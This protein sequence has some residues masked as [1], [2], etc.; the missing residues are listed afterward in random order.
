MAEDATNSIAAGRYRFRDAMSNLAR[1][2]SLLEADEADDPAAAALERI[3]LDLAE[4]E[5]MPA[6]GGYVVIAHGEQPMDRTKNASGAS[7]RMTRSVHIE[8]G[9]NVPAAHAASTASAKRAAMEW[10]SVTVGDI[11]DQ[12]VDYCNAGPGRP[13]LNSLSIVAG[14]GR[15][16]PDENQP[17][18]SWLFTVIAVS[19]QE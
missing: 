15:L 10:W 13:I 3:Y 4:E 11:C 19:F 18:A 7:Y 6:T 16:N 5:D 9:S 2:Q 1:V 12:L 17:G 8:I 14:P